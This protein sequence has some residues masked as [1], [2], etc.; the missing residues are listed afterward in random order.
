MYSQSPCYSFKAVSHGV[1]ACACPGDTLM[2]Q[3][4]IPSNTSYTVWEGNTLKCCY[5]SEIILPH[6]WCCTYY[7]YHSCICGATTA[8]LL[9]FENG[10]YTS[11]LNITIESR[12]ELDNKTISCLSDNGTTE[13]LIGQAVITPTTSKYIYSRQIVAT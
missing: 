8:Q 1:N 12:N 10:C 6:R 3:C 7:N 5:N 2:Y 13:T 4:S 11:Q 9:R